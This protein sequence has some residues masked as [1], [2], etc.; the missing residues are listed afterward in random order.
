MINDRR[1]W[2]RARVVARCTAHAVSLLFL[3]GCGR[4]ESTAPQPA[5]L[6]TAATCRTSG[7][8]YAARFI[9]FGGGELTYFPLLI[10][11]ESTYDAVEAYE[12]KTPLIEAHSLSLYY[13]KN[14]TTCDFS[15]HVYVPNLTVLPGTRWEL[16]GKIACNGL[17][18]NEPDCLP[19][20]LPINDLLWHG[21]RIIRT[22]AE[23]ETTYRWRGARLVLNGSA[24]SPGGISASAA[25]LYLPGGREVILAAIEYRR[26][27]P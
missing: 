19:H 6:A 1:W 16:M 17:H 24:E 22:T 23:P 27:C 4:Q 2:T 18:V 7:L 20:P 12:L 3:L 5:A 11:P 14:L 8:I 9:G 21:E 26:D 25:H 13:A 10:Q 15:G